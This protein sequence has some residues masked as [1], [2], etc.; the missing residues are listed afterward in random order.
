VFHFEHNEFESQPGY[1][2]SGTFTGQE[3]TLIHRLLAGPPTYTA[4][5]IPMDFKGSISRTGL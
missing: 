5:S 1:R 2:G 3:G 4:L